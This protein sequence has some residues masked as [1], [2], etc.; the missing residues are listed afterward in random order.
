M[1]TCLV[2]AQLIVCLLSFVDLDAHANCGW[3]ASLRTLGLAQ[4]ATEK[5]GPQACNK[6]AFPHVTHPQSMDHGVQGGAVK[7]VDEGGWLKGHKTWLRTKELGL[8][9]K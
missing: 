6:K 1:K 3:S 7:C 5:A 9:R 2:P 4:L 8:E